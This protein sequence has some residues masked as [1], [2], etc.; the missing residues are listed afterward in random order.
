MAAKIIDGKAVAAKMREEARTRAA[1]LEARGVRPCLAVVLAGEDP[2]SLSYVAAKEKALA[3]AGMEGREFRLPA[4]VGEAELLGVINA[5]NADETVHGILVQLP[6]P[7]HIREKAVISAMDPAKDVD[8]FHPVS[9][10]N[11]VLGGKGFLPCTPHGV[12]VLLRE[13]GIPTDGAHAV[14]LGRSNIVG[15]PLAALLSRR[16]VNATVTICHTGTRNPG[17]YTKEADIIIAAAGRPGLISAGMVKE[18]AAVIDVGVNRVADSSS[19]KGYR[20]LG[21]V[22][23]GP[24]AEKAGWITPVPGGVGPMTVA[25]LLL[26]V[27]EA[28]ENAANAVSGANT[29]SG[30]RAAAARHD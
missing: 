1:A 30:A 23:Y 15:K 24:V 27:V 11:M 19:K 26:N 2:A 14:I 25:M 3:G 18:G 5:L 22:D 9:V 10:G 8:G 28:A 17:L 4:G 20:L 29:A 6:L 7:S 12:L 21:D 13:E 16:E